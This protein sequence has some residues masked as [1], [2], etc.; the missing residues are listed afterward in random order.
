MNTPFK[1]EW[2]RK[3]IERNLHYRAKF[4][5]AEAAKLDRLAEKL[6]ADRLAGLDPLRAHL[7]AVPRLLGWVPDGLKQFLGFSRFE[8]VSRDQIG[9]RLFHRV[10]ARVDAVLKLPG[11]ALPSEARVVTRDAVEEAASIV[12]QFADGDLEIDWTKEPASE[13]ERQIRAVILRDCTTGGIGHLSKS[14]VFW[15]LKLNQLISIFDKPASD[16]KAEMDR[17]RALCREEERSEKRQQVRDAV[18]RL[19]G[20]A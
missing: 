19:E 3:R 9:D 17:V 10:E 2:A 4:L 15:S 16:L 14:P 11:E 12:R 13:R 6:E 18:R 5:R 20:G 1:N 7:G 8:A